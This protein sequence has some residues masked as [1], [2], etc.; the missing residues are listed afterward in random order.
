MLRVD[1]AVGA[2]EH[3]LALL[4]PGA[5]DEAQA[6]HR[7]IVIADHRLVIVIVVIAPI[8]RAKIAQGQEAEIVV[9]RQAIGERGTARGAQHVLIARRP[10][11]GPNEEGAVRRRQHH[12]LGAIGIIEHVL[13]VALGQFGHQHIAQ[14][15]PVITQPPQP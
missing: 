9:M 12:H 6:W 13:A 10:E 14:K 4:E 5:F 2:V 8:T 7:L 15:L 3:Q 11:V 1:I